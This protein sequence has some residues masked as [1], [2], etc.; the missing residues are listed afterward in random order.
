MRPRRRRPSAR[1][2]RGRFRRHARNPFV[3]AFC[4]R[5]LPGTLSREPLLGWP[6]PAGAHDNVARPNPHAR[7]SSHPRVDRRGATS[8]MCATP[9]SHHHPPAVQACVAPLGRFPPILSSLPTVPTWSEGENGALPGPRLPFPWG[10]QPTQFD[11]P[12]QVARPRL[13][14]PLGTPLSFPTA[15]RPSH[16]LPRQYCFHPPGHWRGSPGYLCPH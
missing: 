13:Q 1:R 16:L 3:L 12:W 6:N 2:S 9:E 5:L 10:H 15:S 14:P 11:S 4:D 7:L 8:R